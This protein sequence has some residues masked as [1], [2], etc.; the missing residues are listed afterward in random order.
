TRDQGRRRASPRRAPRPCPARRLGKDQLRSGREILLLRRG[1]PQTRGSSGES[2]WRGRIGRERLCSED[3]TTTMAQAPRPAEWAQEVVFNPVF[4]SAPDW[5]SIAFAPRK[6]QPR[7]VAALSPLS[8]TMARLPSS[9]NSQPF[10]IRRR[11]EARTQGSPLPAWSQPVKWH[12]VSSS[13]LA[14]WCRTCSR[15][16]SV[17]QKPQ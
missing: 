15:V 17:P 5:S 12:A 13:E 7:T 9:I 11:P 2:L 3:K 16:S 6:V 14:P 8:R 10:T 4:T 1:P